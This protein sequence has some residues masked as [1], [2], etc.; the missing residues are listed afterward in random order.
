MSKL[1]NKCEIFVQTNAEI[2]DVVLQYMYDENLSFIKLI[3]KYNAPFPMSIIG[4]FEIFFKKQLLFH[5]IRLC[6]LNVC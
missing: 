4:A 2:M 5:T 3:W 1:P 6:F